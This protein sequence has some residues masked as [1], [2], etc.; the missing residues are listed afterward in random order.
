MDRQ[1]IDQT[2]SEVHLHRALYLIKFLRAMVLYGILSSCAILLYFVAGIDGVYP[3]AVELIQAIR[4]EFLRD[5]QQGGPDLLLYVIAVSI[6][7][8]GTIFVFIWM[9]RSI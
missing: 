7:I 5:R 2:V 9:Y 8:V 3:T 1:T 6:L 4:A